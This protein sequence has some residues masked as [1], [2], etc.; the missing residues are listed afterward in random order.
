MEFEFFK[1]RVC[2]SDLILVSFLR[3]PTPEPS[4]LPALSRRLCNRL[5]G[6]GGSGVVYIL[7]RQDNRFLVRYFLPTGKESGVSPDALVCAAQYLFDSGNSEPTVIRLTESGIRRDIKVLDSTHFTVRLDN[8]AL[9][10]G[11]VL[12]EQQDADHAEYISAQGKTLVTYPIFIL[13]PLSVFFLDEESSGDW[14]QLSKTVWEHS[15]CALQPVG[16][17]VYTPEDLR[18][19]VIFPGSEKDY[20]T[21]AGAAAVVSILNGFCDR[22]VFVRV[23]RCDLHVSWDEPSNDLFVTAAAAYSFSGF[24]YYDVP[25]SGSR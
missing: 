22:Q 15:G 17:R 20:I 25:P 14:K 13:R 11:T 12:R 18:I 16:T 5:R 7:Q 8:P 19:R 2:G 24:F 23:G 10:D 4:L 1:L 3:L 21:C 6:V 9:P